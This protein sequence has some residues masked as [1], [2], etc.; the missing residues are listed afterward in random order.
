MTKVQQRQEHATTQ[1]AQQRIAEAL[2]IGTT[3]ISA[4]IR[5]AVAGIA[6]IR[7]FCSDESFR[8]ATVGGARFVDLVDSTVESSVLIRLLR[9]VAN[10]IHFRCVEE[11]SLCVYNPEI[12]ELLESYTFR[13]QEDEAGVPSLVAVASQTVPDH[14]G[15]AARGS[16]TWPRPEWRRG[17]TPLTDGEKSE[18]KGA[19][20]EEIKR[21]VVDVMR[22]VEELP[23]LAPHRALVMRLLHRMDR[24]PKDGL[25][26]FS[27]A[28]EQMVQ[29]Y[30]SE[31]S[32]AVEQQR[33]GSMN[34]CGCKLK[35]L[36][37]SGKRAVK[38]PRSPTNSRHSKDSSA[39]GETIP[40][41]V[42][43]DLN[44]DVLS[45]DDDKY[46]IIAAFALSH[47]GGSFFL[48]DLNAF[49]QTNLEAL[50]GIP[51]PVISAH[52]ARLI[53]DGVVVRSSW[54]A[55]EVPANDFTA[56]LLGSLVHHRVATL[57][58]A[59]TK[60]ELQRR[61][62]GYTHARPT[63]TPEDDNARKRSRE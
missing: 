58:D 63:Q 19:A 11:F 41:T 37:R 10:A 56:G 55:C 46:L 15:K 24:V 28:R 23:P 62:S 49:R 14:Q 52:L 40:L 1:A 61:L 27:Q 45:E 60:V 59:K 7:G 31:P 3:A 8:D 32:L 43:V 48:S 26:G 51:D 13:I 16:R 5:Y 17:E 33:M 22:V 35:L 57:L 21:F 54:N 20:M 12:T 38:T 6:Y 30:R 53:T 36:F 18:L 4:S 44:D 2:R 39:I 34:T 29:L 42:L 25:D 50:G 9:S 47:M